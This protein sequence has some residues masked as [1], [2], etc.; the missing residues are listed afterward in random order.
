MNKEITIVFVSFFSKKKILSY[1]KQFNDKFKVIIIENSKDY[2]LLKKTKKY[3]NVKVIINKKNIGFG[4]SSNLGLK[5][6]KT[7]YGLHLDIDTKFSNNSILKLIDI[8]N[9]IDDFIVIGPK[10]QNYNYKPKHYLKRNFLKNIN[11]MNF[12]DGCCLLFNINK[13]K[14]YGLFD[15]NF[16]LY[17]EETDLFRRYRKFDQ[18]ILMTE[19]VKIYHQGRSSSNKIYNNEI[20]I[21]R[22]W[23]LLWSKFYY[24]QKHYNYFIA[25]C[26]VSKNLFSSFFKIMIYTIL[27]ND[28]KK[29]IY[30]ARFLGAM[31]SILRKKSWYRPKI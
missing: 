18:K 27:K 14:R 29:K 19:D 30:L 1:L 24:Y 10:I 12:I 7:K 26:L 31:N 13:I 25:I 23:H 20:E 16:F 5:K 11:L 21:N 22:N 9:K 6:I 8:A 2:S 17:F 3:K 15:E 28:F 4:S